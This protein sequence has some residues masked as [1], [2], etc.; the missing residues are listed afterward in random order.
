MKVLTGLF[1]FLC[2][3]VWG[4]AAGWE[5]AH[6][7]VAT[8]CTRIGAFYVADYTFAC[9]LARPE[10]TPSAKPGAHT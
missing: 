5:E 7:T 10:P 8:E 1:V 6:R 4:F 3:G 9:R 2:G